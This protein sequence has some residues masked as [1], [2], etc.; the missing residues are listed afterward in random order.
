MSRVNAASEAL[1]TTRAWT[2]ATVGLSISMSSSALARDEKNSGAGS[3]KSRYSPPANAKFAPIA[4]LGRNRESGTL[5]N[6]RAKLGLRLT[7]RC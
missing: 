7:W 3:G 2:V 4:Q 5:Q 6:K 1:I